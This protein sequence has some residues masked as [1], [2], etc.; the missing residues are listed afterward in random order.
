[1]CYSVDGR[2]VARR[3]HRSHCLEGRLKGVHEG[4]REVRFLEF[5][6]LKLTGMCFPIIMGSRIMTKSEAED[7]ISRNVE[8]IG[9]ISVKIRH[10]KSVGAGR[11]EAAPARTDGPCLIN[12]RSKKAGSHFVS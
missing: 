2:T 3:L 8:D 7:A 6:N 1:M 5:A 10:I 12:E 4:E 11:I 9:V